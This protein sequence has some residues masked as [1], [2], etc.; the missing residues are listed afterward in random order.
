MLYAKIGAL[1][2]VANL[3]CYI[4][5]ILLVIEC[6]KQVNYAEYQKGKCTAKGDCSILVN[7]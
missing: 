3:K 1:C 7:I 4:L 6:L 2:T 5:Q